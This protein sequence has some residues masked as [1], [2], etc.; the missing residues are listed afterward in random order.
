MAN[1][2]K[3]I[4]DYITPKAGAMSMKILGSDGQLYDSKAL[5]LYKGISDLNKSSNY[6]D[7]TT[8]VGGAKVYKHP[9]DKKTLLLGF[10][11]NAY[12][13]AACKVKSEYIAGNSYTLVDESETMKSNVAKLWSKTMKLFT[14]EDAKIVSF[15][16][17]LGYDDYIVNILS[18]FA[19]D[20]EWSGDACLEVI[21]DATKRIRKVRHIPALNVWKK[22]AGGF[23]EYKQVGG[24]Y[25]TTHY[26]DFG[27]LV[28]PGDTEMIHIRNK[29]P[30]SEV[31]GVPDIANAWSALSKCVLID[32]N[33]ESF[34]YNNSVPAMVVILEGGK[35]QDGADEVIKQHLR[36]NVKGKDHKTL[37]LNVTHKDA[38]IRFEPLGMTL[39]EGNFLQLKKE[40]RAE[41]FTVNRVPPAKC[42]IIETGALA[43]ESTQ[44]QIDD[45]ENTI[46]KK[47][48]RIQD[49]MD[50]L[51]QASFPGTPF[52]YK[53]LGIGSRV[54]K[55]QV[56]T[57]AMDVISSTNELRAARGLDA[58]EHPDAD[59]PRALLGVGVMP[60]EP[61]Y[62][63]TTQTQP[64][65]AAA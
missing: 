1:R 46:S 26:R 65:L 42:G 8:T 58:S 39:K 47:Q 20:L 18:D 15:I 30:L 19:L 9:I 59:T 41:I 51:I 12:H 25:N 7:Q 3:K 62:G 23:I 54:T 2:S 24:K 16:D 49:V 13:Y 33:H 10:T 50:K 44:E 63:D 40:A 5:Q 21:R 36:D 27:N 4:G 55:Q 6:S 38:K 43:G 56:Q 53:V 31:Y 45:F 64:N 17:A 35:W 32:E 57:D 34:F 61:A 37:V 14:K 60:G 11:S 22:V 28:Q 52:I 29:H 48:F